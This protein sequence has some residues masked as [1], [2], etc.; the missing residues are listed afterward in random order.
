MLLSEKIKYLRKTKG[1]SQ[2]D[3]AKELLIERQTISRWENNVTRPD[4]YNLELISELFEVSYDWL[5]K[6]DFGIEDL[7]KQTFDASNLD[8]EVTQN[9]KHSTEPHDSPGL[10]PFVDSFW[11][12]FVTSA[13]TQRRLAY[14]LFFMTFATGVFQLAT[15]LFSIP[16][17]VIYILAPPGTL[18]R[19]IC[20]L[21]FMLW[22]GYY[23]FIILL[24]LLGIGMWYS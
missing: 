8:K 13:S 16:F 5:L 4:P 7:D 10:K 22:V 17:S 6:E 14:T 23:L 12:L 24:L 19:K 9:N 20:L 3:M 15:L 11:I 18:L 21:I 1:Y 2:N